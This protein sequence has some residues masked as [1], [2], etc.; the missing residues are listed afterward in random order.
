M[1]YTR[2]VVTAENINY[3]VTQNWNLI[4][5]E[6]AKKIPLTGTFRLEGDID[7]DNQFT[8]KGIVADGPNTAYPNGN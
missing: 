4:Y 6:L 5:A 1:A 3:A 2:I 8:I 7:F